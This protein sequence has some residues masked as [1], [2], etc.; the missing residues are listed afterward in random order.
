MCFIEWCSAV[1]PLFS[2][3]LALIYHTHTHTL[4]RA[5][6]QA[7]SAVDIALWDLL[8]KLKKQPVYA[9][10][11][12]KTKVNKIINFALCSI[13]IPMYNRSITQ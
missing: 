12:G 4:H 1:L 2:E 7:I 3:I 10:L 9:L 13:I 11:G 6:S 8:G 5:H